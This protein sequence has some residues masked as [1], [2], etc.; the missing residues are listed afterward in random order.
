[1]I[2]GASGRLAILKNENQKR[3]SKMIMGYDTI[4]VL[5]SNQGAAVGKPKPIKIF[6]PGNH[7]DYSGRK[8]PVS[9][10]A[11]IAMVENFNAS[12]KR[13]PLVVGHPETNDEKFGDVTK[14]E[15]DN[16]GRVLAAEFADLSNGFRHVVGKVG[17]KISAKLRLPGHPAN[18][19]TGY[20]LDHVGFFF[21]DEQVALAD[22]PIAKFAEAK[23]SY[24]SVKTMD[25]EELKAREDA[26]AAKEAE[27]A[28]KE[29]EFAAKAA[30][31]PVVAELV[32]SGYVPPADQET[33]S[34]IFARL[35]GD[36][37]FA[38]SFAAG[39]ESPVAALTRILKVAKVPLG[40]SDPG[41]GSEGDG[42]EDLAVA[43]FMAPSGDLDEGSAKMDKKIRSC[44]AK[45]GLSYGAA[46]KKVMKE[47]A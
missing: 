9:K 44:M 20:E 26:I 46:R 34:A 5:V 18:K 24:I 3:L 17:A 16:R 33:I 21:G 27:F 39:K 37:G 7:T 12:G 13:I 42:E 45:D 41:D 43:H 2:L 23:I 30:V 36:T 11:L 22:L 35:E 32:A 40:E 19:S 10:D 38:V 28:A 6:Y 25:E 14:L 31:A 47:A 8:V 29:A 4:V 1:M 15:I